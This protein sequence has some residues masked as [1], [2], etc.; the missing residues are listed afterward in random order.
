M[1]DKARLGF[2]ITFILLSGLPK[3]RALAVPKFTHIQS[4]MPQLLPL[5][6]FLK[7][8]LDRVRARESS[9]PRQLAEVELVFRNGAQ[10]MH[11]KHP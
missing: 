5:T 8:T 7:A 9:Q 1:K 10:S 4:A 6:R 11:T 3:N 2:F